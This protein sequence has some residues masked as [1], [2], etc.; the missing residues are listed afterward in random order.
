MN[1][2]VI[3][4]PK[5]KSWRKRNQITSRASR[6]APARKAA[7]SR[8]RAR[9]LRRF[10][11]GPSPIG[12]HGVHRRRPPARQPPG[13]GRREQVESRREEGGAAQTERR[14]QP[15]L[16]G[17]GAQHAAQRV[18]AVETSQHGAEVAVVARNGAGEDGQGDAHRRGGQQHQREGDRETQQ[19]RQPGGVA[20]PAEQRREQRRQRR[21][22]QHGRRPRGADAELQQ[23]I[24]AQRPADARRPADR[25]RVAGRQPG[26]ERGQHDARRPDAA[27]EHQPG[28]PQPE[29]L[30][31]QR[32]GPG[33]QRKARLRR[34]AMACGQHTAAARA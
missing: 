26:H 19:I 34:A 24:G 4:V 22:R 32:R 3:A 30:E 14:D 28:A 20:E 25:Q 1:A 31:Q 12:C 11:S 10:R 18:P 7:A 5:R 16:A 8:R 13:Q 23:R 27:A 21:R 15:Q 2:N 29:R 6:P 33:Q 17:D 9:G